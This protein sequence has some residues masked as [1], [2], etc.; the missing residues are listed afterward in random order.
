MK[1]IKTLGRRLFFPD[2]VPGGVTGTGG[3]CRNVR[4]TPNT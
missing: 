1:C 2:V 3:C 4:G